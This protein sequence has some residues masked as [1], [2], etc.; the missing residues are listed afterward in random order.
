MVLPVRRKC[1]SCGRVTAVSPPD[2]FRPF[3]SG[4]CRLADL[5]KWL[6]GAYR[7]G[8]PVAEE[9]LDQGAQPDDTDSER[10]LS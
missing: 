1:P 5:G 3:C 8:S 2:S 7:I 4:R 9:D 10:K 6:D